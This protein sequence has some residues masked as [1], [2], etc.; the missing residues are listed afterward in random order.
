MEKIYSFVIPHSLLLMLKG[1]YLMLKVKYSAASL[2]S[3]ADQSN[4]EKKRK[5]NDMTQA[6]E[7]GDRERASEGVSV[8]V[9][10]P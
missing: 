4:N 8:L 7:G 2:V 6:G 10:Q 1:C 5:I 3:T 9:T